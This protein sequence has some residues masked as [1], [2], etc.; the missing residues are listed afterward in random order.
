MRPS[1]RPA[2]VNRGGALRSSP[3]RSRRSPPQTANATEEIGTQIA[4]MQGRDAGVRHCD[5][6]D[7]RHDRPHLGN[8]VY[9]RG[10]SRRAGCR[11]AGDRAQ[12]AA[13]C[14]RYDPEVASKITDV[15]SWCR[16]DRLGVLLNTFLGQSL[17]SESNHLELEVAD[18]SRRCGLRKKANTPEARAD[19]RAAC[20]RVLALERSP[21]ARLTP[22]GTPRR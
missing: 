6:G 7:R 17:S 15:K 11:D 5:Q 1:R 21:P 20:L 10:S 22:S 18:S 4:S 19:I 12:C 9:H 16:R 14:A 2:R 8:R 3:P 13:G